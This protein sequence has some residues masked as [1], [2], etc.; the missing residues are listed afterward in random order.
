MENED[1]YRDTK[2]VLI[3]TPYTKLRE[4]K[5]WT[6]ETAADFLQIGATTL[7][8]YENKKAAIP[9]SVIKRMDEVYGCNGKLIQYWWECDFCSCP[10]IEYYSRLKNL[11]KNLIRRL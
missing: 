11:I 9:K 2:I 5:G 10:K 7:G 1:L 3:K 8:R 4:K 6:L